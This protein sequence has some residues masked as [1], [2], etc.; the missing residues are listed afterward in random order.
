MA[1]S[2][3]PT[4]LPVTPS[5][6]ISGSNR[7]GTRA[8][9]AAR[10]GFDHHESETAPASPPETTRA[11]ASPRNCVFS[12][13]LISPM[14]CTPG[15]SMSGKISLREVVFIDLVDL[16]GDF[17][18][19]ASSA[20]NPDR[21]VRALFRRNPPQEGEVVPPLKRRPMQV[22]RNAVVY[23]RNIICQRQG[24]ALVVRD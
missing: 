21:A 19:Y 22:G 11:A 23:R 7:N 24:F 1:S 15:P 14:N 16:G 3:L 2:S 10:H 17:Q 13:S 5:S 6:L 20:R 9:R 8:R 18:R 4:T 12:R